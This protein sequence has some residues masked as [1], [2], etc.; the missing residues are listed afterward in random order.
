MQEKWF[1]LADRVVSLGEKY[2]AERIASRA[3]HEERQE[4]LV[5]M[6]LEAV[7]KL[8][9]Q[10]VRERAERAELKMLWPDTQDEMTQSAPGGSGAKSETFGPYA[11]ATAHAFLDK[12]R[13]YGMSVS[14]DNPWTIDARQHGI[15][16]QAS[17]DGSGRVTVKISEKNF[18]VSNAK[19]WEK[20]EPLMPKPDVVGD[21][22]NAYHVD[23]GTT[24]WN[25][26]SSGDPSPSGK[27]AH[28]VDLPPD[29]VKSR[30]GNFVRLPI[31]WIADADLRVTILGDASPTRWNKLASQ[32][33]ALDAAVGV[34]LETV[35]GK[36]IG[37]VGVDWTPP[38]STDAPGHVAYLEHAYE[39]TK[40]A[41]EKAAALPAAARGKVQAAGKKVGTTAVEL[42]QAVEEKTKNIDE[43]LSAR[44]RAV[45]EKFKSTVSDLAPVYLGIGIGAW[46]L[47][48]AGV[49]LYLQG[50][51]TK[52]AA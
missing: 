50:K 47:I 17:L 15:I 43:E 48:G 31:G 8:Y 49:Y 24:L 23:A 29:A 9:G 3:A 12:V 18:Y 42:A 38:T 32:L 34:R 10:P 35:Q 6:A 21:A 30:S 25:V 52:A 7:A 45:K 51:K 26:P 16:L 19:I 22:R 46:L 1:S 41:L 2:I 20:V 14:G 13:H 28:D 37:I 36:T 27:L 4:K 44:A 33:E 5:A 39:H 11:P 40:D